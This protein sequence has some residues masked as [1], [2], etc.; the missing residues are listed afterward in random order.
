[1]AFVRSG[2]I[3]FMDMTREVQWY[4]FLVHKNSIKFH[5]KTP[6]HITED[7]F[8]AISMTKRQKVKLTGKKKKKR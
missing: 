2:E 5:E 6:L 8:Y 3:C 1:L 4:V 7:R